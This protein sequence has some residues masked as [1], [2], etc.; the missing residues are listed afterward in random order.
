MREQYAET[1]V[2]DG[3]LTEEE[4]GREA[5][6]AYQRL[7]DIQQSFKASTGTVTKE[8]QVRLSGAGQE[9]ETALA[10]EFL[11]ALNEQ[12]L[13]WPEGFTVHPSCGSSSSGGAPR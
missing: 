5:D 12:L 9:V 7:L 13:S 1:L 11:R 3:V 4:A 6:Q 8:H 2:Q 10:P